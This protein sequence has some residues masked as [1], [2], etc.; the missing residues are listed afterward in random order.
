LRKNESQAD[1]KE[2]PFKKGTIYFSNVSGNF[3][4]AATSVTG[5]QSPCDITHGYLI[6]RLRHV[7]ITN[8][9]QKTFTFVG[10]I[11]QK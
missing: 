3:I 2:R 8:D 4:Q 10:D 11:S 1:E 6:A 9:R 5:K 7:V